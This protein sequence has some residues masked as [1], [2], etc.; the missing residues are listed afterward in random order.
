MKNQTPDPIYTEIFALIDLAADAFE[1]QHGEL[2]ESS[3][4]ELYGQQLEQVVVEFNKQNG[5]DYE[6]KDVLSKWTSNGDNFV[7]EL[8]EY[9]DEAMQNWNNLKASLKG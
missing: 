5:S 2:N 4:F 3:D 7:D 9:M 6:P 1:K 8:A